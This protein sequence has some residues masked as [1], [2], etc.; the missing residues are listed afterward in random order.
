M[1]R[2]IACFKATVQLTVRTAVQGYH[3]YREVWALTVDKEFDC[4]QEVD[5]REDRYPVA[6]YGNTQSSTCMYSAWTPSSSNFAHILHVL[7]AQGYI[8]GRETGNLSQLASTRTEL[9]HLT[10]FRALKQ[11][12]EKP[13]IRHN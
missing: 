13:E 3:V 7:G 11:E 1:V 6:V 8:T 10:N 2:R 5:N 12:L 4:Q 9:I